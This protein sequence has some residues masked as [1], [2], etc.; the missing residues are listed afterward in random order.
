MS[1]LLC[2]TP[3]A[4]SKEIFTDEA[5]ASGIDF[6]H[7]NGMSGEFYFVE[8]LGSGA[9][10]FDY[11]NDGDLDLYLGQGH[12]LGKGKTL[13][14]AL[15][16]PPPGEKFRDRLY[17]NDMVIHKDGRRSLRFTEVTEAS[18]LDARGYSMGAAVGDYDND[19][20]LDLYLTNFGEDQ[21]WRNNGDGTFS[22]VT[23][24]AGLGQSGW[25]V[26]A[27]FLDYDL[28]GHLDLYVGRYVDFSTDK[29]KECFAPTSGR[30]YCSPHI[31]D[32]LPDLLYRNRGDGS[33]ED[34]SKKS[35]I[36]RDFG[37]A[38]GVIVADFNGDARVDI[39]AAND[40][41]PNQLWINRAN[42][43]FVN[44][45]LL[46][47]VA[48]NMEGA[49]EASM[50]V[51]AADLDG[52]GDEDLFMTHLQGETNTIYVN[53]GEGWFEDRSLATGLGAPSK[54]FTSFGTGWFD[55]ANN[56]MLDLFVANGEVR[57]VPFLAR[58][59]DT[60]PLNQTN[61]LFANLGG[62][63]Y[64]DITAEAGKVFQLSEVSRGA[65]FGDVD[66]DGDT[67]ILVTNNNGRARL[68]INNV[69][70]Q[71]HW[72]GLRVLDDLGRDAIG[73]RVAVSV[74]KSRMLWRRVRTDG[75]YASANDPRLLVGLGDSSK[76]EAVRVFWPNGDVEEWKGIPADQYTNLRKGEGK[77]VK[78]T[79]RKP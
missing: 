55:Y 2:T 49:P 13:A 65:A 64:K 79:V 71:N 38:L 5:Q 21:L 4:F 7:F 16:P 70:N 36:D 26:S 20:W 76:L 40:M 8:P 77:A 19:G 37:P 51:D 14:N 59:G 1:A 18:G 75:S 62:A 60:Y 45:A 31:Y 48:V 63:K 50:G 61:Q 29:N 47:G 3:Q 23:K 43:S 33:F 46:A 57:V 22:D 78:K 39:Y 27:A 74:P 30:D 66:N 56:G 17:R 10:V 24:K 12:M 44:E 67:D 53:N 9:A 15:T 32:P 42:G 25:A 6:V 11:D 34:V 68:L 35:G 41:K 52:D 28:D 72:L 69:G 58:A 73:A 54:A